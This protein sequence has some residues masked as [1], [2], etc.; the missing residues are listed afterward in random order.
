MAARLNRRHQDLVREKIRA[1]MVIDRLEKCALGEIELSPTQV[2]SAKILL[3][4]SLS[5]A[6]TDL[7]VAG[8]MTINWPEPKNALDE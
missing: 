8:E 5:N 7:N 6:A 3:D 4:K 2:Q 1:G